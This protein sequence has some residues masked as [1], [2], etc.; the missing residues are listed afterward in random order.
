MNAQIMNDQIN[1]LPSESI[2]LGRVWR[3]DVEGPAVCFMQNNQIYDITSVE[4]PTMSDVLEKPD[5]VAF[6]QEKLSHASLLGEWSEVV[7]NSLDSSGDLSK[8]HLLAPCDLQAIKACGVTF[9]QSMVE[10]VIEEKASGDFA[11][12]EAI[13]DQLTQSIGESLKNVKAGSQQAAKL[14]QALQEQGLWSQYLEVGI[15]PDAEV[16]TKSQAMSAVGFGAKVG[17]HP[18]S[19]W[20]NPEPEVV[21]AVSSKGKIVGATLGN[22]VN[23]RDV[24]GRS[25]LLLGKAKDNNASC[26]MGP[27]VRLFDE[28]YTLDDVRHAHLDLIVQGQDGFMLKGTSTMSQISRDPEELVKQTIGEHHQ[29]P[30]GFMLF[31]GTLFAPTQDRDT[32]GQGFTH[33]VGDVVSISSEK[34]GTL[35]NTV[36]LSTKCP[37]WTFGIRALMKNL[38]QRHLL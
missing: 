27:L 14:K 19:N 25:A 32:Q 4:A 11:K 37:Q 6:V 18:M 12:A 23:L 28:H 17:I 36:E 21:L 20:N 5:P 13:R 26:A 35:V 1:Q 31:M 30:D 15:G 7:K 8:V 9:A 24:E 2:L 22:D 34:L 16:F 10:R 33:K 38:A 29:Y 3:P